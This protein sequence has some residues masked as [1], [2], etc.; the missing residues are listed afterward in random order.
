M[1]LLEAKLRSLIPLKETKQK[2]NWLWIGSFILVEISAVGL[3][4]VYWAA[5]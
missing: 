2:P 1:R 3:V 5:R 4:F